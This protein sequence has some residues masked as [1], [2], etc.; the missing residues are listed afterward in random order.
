[1][2]EELLLDVQAEL[3]RCGEAMYHLYGDGLVTWIE[4]MAKEF[5]VPGHRTT[6]WLATWVSERPYFW[7]E[8]QK[9]RRWYAEFNAVPAAEVAAHVRGGRP[10]RGHRRL[11]GFEHL[12]NLAPDGG[13]VDEVLRLIVSGGHGRVGGRASSD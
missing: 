13:V 9:A 1:M 11:L 7:R 5:R 3:R 2:C 6:A 8:S 10:V 12:T 4:E